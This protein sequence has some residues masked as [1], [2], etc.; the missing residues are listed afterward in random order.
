MKRLLI[1]ALSLISMNSIAKM[2]KSLKSLHGKTVICE[3]KKRI[4]LDGDKLHIDSKRVLKKY[5]PS[6]I[7]NIKPGRKSILSRCSY[8]PS[9]KKTTCD[10]YY[11]TAVAD[12]KPFFYKLVKFYNFSTQFDVQLTFF[13]NKIGVIENNGRG[14]IASGR[15]S[16]N[17]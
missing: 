11:S 4:A 5:K 16:I 15:C 9:K 8:S 1:V 12:F 14:G 6:V 3:I 10:S 17:N 7:I 2:P 13:K